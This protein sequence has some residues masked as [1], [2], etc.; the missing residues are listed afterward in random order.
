MVT[1]SLKYL[2]FI[3]WF[4]PVV[5]YAYS[6]PPNC[7][8]SGY[9]LNYA[10]ATNAFG[11]VSLGGSGGTITLGTSASATNPQRSGDA[12]TG[13]YSANAGE[14]DFG[15]NVSGTGTQEGYFTS[16]GLTLVNPLSVASGGDAQVGGLTFNSTGAASANSTAIN[17]ALTN[18]G[19]VTVDCPTG[20]T[21]YIGAT[22]VIPSYSSLYVYPNCNPTAVSG[23]A[24]LVTNKASQTSWTTLYDNS[25]VITTGPLS[26][27]NLS[28]VSAW[29]NNSGSGTSYTKGTYVSANS[30][31][32]WESVSS[33]TGATSG[34]GPS[35][36]GSGITDGT[37]SWNYITTN[38]SNI[39]NGQGVVVHYPSHGLSLG[40]AIWLTP[41]GD[42]SLTGNFWSGTQS[43]HTRG[44]PV[45]AAY[46]GIFPIINVNDSNY[47]TVVLRRSQAA[48]FTGIPMLVK[49]ADQNVYLGGGAV[50]NGNY[51]TNSTCSAPAVCHN[52]LF[53]GVMNLVIDGAYAENQNRFEFLIAGVENADIGHI[54]IGPLGA[55]YDGIKFYGPDFDV[56]LHD[57]FGAST[58]SYNTDDFLSFNTEEDSTYGT[59]VIAAGDILNV[60]TTNVT[61][62]GGH[63]IAL[64]QSQPY[65]FM[66]DLDFSGV[67]GN[68]LQSYVPLS[69]INDAGSTSGQGGT[70]GTLKVHNMTL[71]GNSAAAAV[72]YVNAVGLT[73]KHL[74]LDSINTSL[75]GSNLYL[76]N[77]TGGTIGGVE[78]SNNTGL[79]QGKLNL[80]AG[81]SIGQINFTNNN[82]NCNNCRVMDAE[83]GTLSTLNI[84]NNEFS[85]GASNLVL[86]KIGIDV[87][88]VNNYLPTA[89]SAF[90]NL[91]SSD[92]IYAANNVA[93]NNTGGLAVSTGAITSTITSGGGNVFSGNS[94][95][96]GA[97]TQVTQGVINNV[98][99]SSGADIG[100]SSTNVDYV[101]IA[102]SA[103]G[104]PG[105]VTISAQGTDSNVNIA[106]TP[107]GTGITTTGANFE[108]IGGQSLG[109]GNG[110][111]WFAHCSTTSSSVY[112]CVNDAEWISVGTT[113]NI[114]LYG[115]VAGAQ[116]AANAAGTALS[117]TGGA[118]GATSGAGGA[119]TLAGGAAT[120]S[121]AGG[122]VTITGGAAAGSAQNGGNVTITGGAD[123][124]GGTQG[125]IILATPGGTQ[126]EITDTASAVDYLK[127]KGDATAT[128]TPSITAAGTDSNVSISLTPKGSGVVSVSGTMSATTFS[129]AGTSLTGTASS[130][131]AGTVTT[132][133][134][135]TGP[136]T[137]SGNATS[138]AG[139]AAGTVF[140]GATPAMTA[141]PVLGVNASTSGTLGLAN[142]GG[143]GATTTVEATQATSASNFNLPAPNS[144]ASYVLQ[145]DGSG[146]TSWVD[147]SNYNFIYNPRFFINQ[148][149]GTSTQT[150]TPGSTIYHVSDN[151]DLVYK[152]T[153]ITTG[154]TAAI[155]V[156]GPTN[157]TLPLALKV[158]T[159]T[160]G[161][162][163]SGDYIIVVPGTEG[164][165]WA[166]MGFGGANA[167]PFSAACWV[168]T[169]ASGVVGMTF[170]NNN[171]SR[172]YMYG[173]N[174]T[175]TA[176]T[177][178]WC[179]AQN[180]PG[181]QAG[182]W[183]STDG[184]IGLYGPHLVF[185]S[186]T[187]VQWSSGQN[188]W[189]NVANLGENGVQSNFV[190]SNGATFEVTGC[191]I[192]RGNVSPQDIITSSYAADW[193]RAQRYQQCMGDIVGPLGTGAA[194]ST[195]AAGFFIPFHHKMDEAP[196]LIAPPTVADFSVFSYA[197]SSVHTISAMSLAAATRDG[198]GV[199]IT[200]S[201][202]VSG[203]PYALEVGTALAGNLCFDAQPW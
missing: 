161:S 191:E 157:Y 31:L 89:T 79:S 173:S 62:Y 64:Y 154:V 116:G 97:G 196:A 98:L 105:T 120:T 57:V 178:T 202:L 115:P 111:A 129:G 145:N 92:S 82:I 37:C 83:S 29:S 156:D 56:R 50:W 78:E 84:V 30:N 32:Y 86:D 133:A 36:T 67:Q 43:A 153:N 146:N 17:A 192:K 7:T 121:G 42:A 112:S 186:G 20:S 25:G 171:D 51:P 47:V 91:Q 177:W 168:K 106:L 53:A 5:A 13:L 183:Q 100:L 181:D 19:R 113:S 122:S 15:V 35:G 110:A 104:S 18:G 28:N 148:R 175:T 140:A 194:T 200:S 150:I 131:T 142:G 198:A 95:F 109:V 94:W 40:Q 162:M 114:T 108:V 87:S 85:S 59:S 119:T 201:S 16:S 158:T 61:A 190:S 195:T 68:N 49:Q 174:C 165:E 93:P 117:F 167:E 4:L 52:I 34:T 48:A 125:I 90:I 33:C 80:V 135:L 141:T 77:F 9:G 164:S 8:T 81:A 136:I 138:V 38:P 72:I 123:T 44:G 126:A 24:P 180:I 179:A 74:I 197:F 70:I 75:V 73:L 69:V 199:T 76:A 21:L 46:L 149:W 27:I 63:A 159:T 39:Y 101:Q 144:T 107:L 23:V 193:D 58:D 147:R 10:T 176:N 60:Q 188:A 163:A 71:P 184:S 3:F 103:T 102:G 22:L 96:S 11:C 65:L 66:D 166:S 88:F 155:V 203:T 118:G 2:S 182:T 187:G 99:Y 139:A 45:D 41:E 185:A 130:L 124:S 128:H 143:S 160:G 172:G 26:L 169:S 55:P 127:I 12:K 54:G 137:S 14:L 134:N 152:T 170:A 132:N 151:Y 1:K 189:G 6:P